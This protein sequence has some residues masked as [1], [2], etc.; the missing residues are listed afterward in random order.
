MLGLNME[1]I[2]PAALRTFV[3]EQFIS[4]PVLM[5]G[6]SPKTLLGKVPG[7][8]TTYLISPEGKLVGRQVGPVDAKSLERFIAGYG[9]NKENNK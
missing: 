2:E 9:K 1:E 5:V 8:P 3:E 4:Y 7:L 6:V